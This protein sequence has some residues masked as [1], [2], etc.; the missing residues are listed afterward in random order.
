MSYLTEKAKSHKVVH[1]FSGK[2]H[3]FKVQST[4]EEH[5]VSIQVNCD[6]KFMGVVG[7]PRGKVCT[8]ILAAF[9]HVLENGLDVNYINDMIQKRSNNC[10]NLVRKGNRKLNEFRKGK[11][12]GSKHIAKKREIFDKL[13]SEHKSV[14]TEAIFENGKRADVLCLEEFK[15]YE[16]VDSESEESIAK[17]LKEYPRGLKI[18]VIR[19]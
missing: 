17:K 11:N 10:L 13:I 16:I 8:H 1:E 4:N 5:N 9:N 12:E 2:S 18:E 19:V 7:T 6:C 15:V 3:F 14:I